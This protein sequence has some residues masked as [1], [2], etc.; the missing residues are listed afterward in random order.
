MNV[1]CPNCGGYRTRIGGRRGCLLD[2]FRTAGLL[3]IGLGIL[4]VPIGCV[5]MLLAAHSHHL[6]GLQ[7][8]LPA[9]LMA[10]LGALP[11]MLAR[12]GSRHTW[13]CQICGYGWVS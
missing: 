13:Y 8:L 10:A 4:F 9:L 12:I 1:Q 5:F 11:L 6:A 7:Q 2:L 3:L